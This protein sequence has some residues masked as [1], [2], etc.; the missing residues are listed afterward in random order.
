ML[1][2]SGVGNSFSSYRAAL[3]SAIATTLSLISFASL[4]QG[5]VWMA[6]GRW[7]SIEAWWFP[8]GISYEEIYFR[9]WLLA[10]VVDIYETVGSIIFLDCFSF[11]LMMLLTREIRSSSLYA[12]VWHHE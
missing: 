11:S 4:L 3:G 9:L 7:T 6:T 2:R 1:P 12:A 5:A 10:P 8:R